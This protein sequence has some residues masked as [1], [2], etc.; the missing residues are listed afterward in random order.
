MILRSSQVA[1][2]KACP[3]KAF[4]TFELGLTP[5]KKGFNIDLFFGSALHKAIEIYRLKN[6]IEATKYVN[7]LKF[8][9][10]PRKN[11]STLLSLVSQY[12]R[13]NNV[14][15][16]EP[17]KFFSFKV[18]SHI[19]KGRF[20]GICRYNNS[21]WVEEHKTTNPQYLLLRPNDQ[22]IAYC[23]GGKVFYHEI[24]GMIINLF[25]V[26]KISIEKKFLSF[27]KDDYEDWIDNMKMT[28]EFY[29]RCRHKQIFPENPGACHMYNRPCTYLSIC[30]TSPGNR[31]MIVKNYFETNDSQ[32]KLE[33]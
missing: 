27:S 29:T 2:F 5:I 6:A 3:A 14:E 17:E 30:S 21:L 8:Q 10:T 23:L 26:D 19:W 9:E 33:W 15:I 1:T 20:D 11:K 12:I 32:R 31:N 24:S 4:Y 18:G 16:I 13:D 28:A 22:F 7:S 25:N